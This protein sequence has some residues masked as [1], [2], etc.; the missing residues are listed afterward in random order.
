MTQKL[1]LGL[2]LILS[3]LTTSIVDIHA[4]NYAEIHASR[5]PGYGVSVASSEDVSVP[6]STI[7][8]RLQYMQTQYPDTIEGEQIYASR[9]VFK[10]SESF[11]VTFTPSANNCYSRKNANL[12]PNALP[13]KA[14]AL[15]SPGVSPVMDPLL[16]QQL[17]E[18]VLNQV[19]DRQT[20]QLIER[21]RQNELLSQRGVDTT[22][23]KWITVKNSRIT[24]GGRIFTDWINWANDAQLGNQPNYVEFRQLRLFAAGEGYGVYDFKLEFDFVPE[25]ASETQII[26]NQ[27]QSTTFGFELKDAYVGIRDL[28][29]LGYLRIGHFKVPFGLEELT[30]AE[31]ITFLE[32]SLPIVFA[33]RRELGL[34]AYN[35][36]WNQNLTWAYGIFFYDFDETA[37]VV[38]DDNQGL[39]AASRVVWTPYYDE[40]SEGRYLLHTGVGYV[41]SRP[42]LVDDPDLPGVSS[43]LV[44]L[45]SRPEIHRGSFLIDT[46]DLDVPQYNTFDAELAWVHGS[47]SIQSELTWTGLEQAIGSNSDLYGVYVYLSYFL[48]GEHR[49]YDRRFGN[50]DRV[51]PYENFWMVRSPHGTC[52]GRG[53]WEAAVRWSFLDFANLNGQQL[54]DLTVGLNWYWNPNTRMMINW[55]HPFAHQGPINP[56]GDAEGDVLAMRLQ[57]DF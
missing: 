55:I 32:R 54:Q 13:G 26:D 5:A 40:A 20:R 24:W 21:D 22:D 23:E 6:A 38:L 14:P 3:I 44:R 12:S 53:A 15:R 46:D 25:E 57:V 50:F 56:L 4:Q 37:M 48:T 35:Q 27:V 49:R 11:D 41:Y 1:G 2:S 45:R 52:A 34:A 28:P 18:D 47:L 19:P 9:D 10:S 42:R 8:P 51:I 17:S 36:T 33:P 31:D 7:Q 39:R 29:L 43:R 16:V 30:S